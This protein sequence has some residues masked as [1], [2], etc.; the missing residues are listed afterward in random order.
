M[1]P[2]S[3]SVVHL[4]AKPRNCGVDFLRCVLMYLIVVHHCCCHSGM[5]IGW[6]AQLAFLLTIPSVD[7]FAGIS[8]W[9]GIRFTW[10]K[11]FKLLF[12]IA[13]CSGSLTLVSEILF[14]LDVTSQRYV[15]IGVGWFGVCYVFMFFASPLID[16]MINSLV[17]V[18][19]GRMLLVLA[20]AAILAV[21]QF[22]PATYCSFIPLS[23]SHSAGTLLLVY[24]T[25]RLFG[26]HGVFP[27]D[28]IHMSVPVMLVSLAL[29]LAIGVSG[30]LER[31]GILTMVF[32]LYASPVVIVLACSVV[33]VMARIQIP[34]RIGAFVSMLA[35]SMFSVYLLHDAHVFGR[36]FL[37]VRPFRSFEGLVAT[38]GALQMVMILIWAAVVF[39]VTL[40]ADVL[41]RRL[42]RMSIRIKFVGFP[43]LLPLAPAA[44]RFRDYIVRLV[45]NGLA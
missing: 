10:R 38:S 3:T 17:R 21:W 12:Q 22:V 39:V 42:L 43:V 44:V 24:F 25:M 4:S 9:F 14:R 41:V 15:S 18:G 30:M 40:T 29:L 34:S 6:M 1:P 36:E 32:G 37:I 16:R 33:T 5:E 27:W 8:G 35:P 7:G 11:L 31:H 45:G 13:I 28:R 20:W 19:L 2:S 26:G 23:G